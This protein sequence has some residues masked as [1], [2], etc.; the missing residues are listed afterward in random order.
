MIIIISTLYSYMSQLSKNFFDMINQALGNEIYLCIFLLPL[1]SLI[2]MDIYRI[3][4][5]KIY[6]ISRLENRIEYFK[7][8]FRIIL[9][10]SMLLL[11]TTLT[12][13]FLLGIVF[14]NKDFS[15]N[16]NNEYGI[17]NMVLLLTNIFKILIFLTT[18]QIINYYILLKNNDKINT[19]III[20]LIIMC[21]LLSKE[22]IYSKISLLAP[23]SHVYINKIS[24][25][26][27]ISNSLIYSSIYH[28]SFMVITII[29]INRS[30]KKSSI[31]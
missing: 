13:L 10:L 28:L 2:V 22:L 4:S 29:L 27:N 24:M 17:S 19:T 26:D 15:I 1:F 11:F 30:I 9:K 6:I 14:C 20:S 18:F 12:I 8:N 3:I 23:A 5:R 25:F 16:F 7:I 21:I 31:I